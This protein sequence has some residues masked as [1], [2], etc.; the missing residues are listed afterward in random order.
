MNN[1]YIYFWFYKNTD[2]VFYIGKGKGNR[3][4][5]R[6]AHRNEYFKNI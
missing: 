2:E 6:K 3:F 5:E 4:L 1:F